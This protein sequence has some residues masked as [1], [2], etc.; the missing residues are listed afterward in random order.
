MNSPIALTEGRRLRAIWA[1]LFSAI[2][3]GIAYSVTSPLIALRLEEDGYS[4][5]IIGLNTTMFPLG[6]LIAGPLMAKII[7]RIGPTLAMASGVFLELAAILL[8]PLF[9][10]I[11]AWFVFRLM[12]G[13]GVGFNWI[14]SESWMNSLARPHRRGLVLAAYITMLSAGFAIGPELVRHVGIEGDS[15]FNLTAMILATSAVGWIFLYP[16]SGAMSREPST[17]LLPIIRLF[18]LAMMAA[19][20]SGILEGAVF[21]FLPI[22]GVSLGLVAE[23][24]LRLLTAFAAG[25][26][27]LQLLIG[28]LADRFRARPVLIFLGAGALACIIGLPLTAGSFA[29]WPIAFAWG[30]VAFGFYTVGLVN[31]GQRAGQSQLT[32]ANAAFVMAYQIGL[33]SGPA[34]SGG[35]IDIMGPDGFIVVLG[36]CTLL[37]CLYAIY[38]VQSSN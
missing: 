31:L 4:A 2:P 11:Y 16:A 32:A 1:L 19:C 8:F 37:F 26:L 35:G 27:V 30:G 21:S 23:D 15:A 18:P 12:L 38:R 24:A 29:I 33:I 34:L 22:Y 9:D 17:A 5:L 10:N 20:I 13:F 14:V 7:R 3:F 6:I 25:N 36:T 28:F